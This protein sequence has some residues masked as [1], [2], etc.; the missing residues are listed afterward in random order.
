MLAVA[1]KTA[2]ERALAG[3]AVA[4]LQEWAYLQPVKAPPQ[5]PQ[6]WSRISLAHM[7][8]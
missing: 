1:G 3:E 6:W 8:G 7:D 5:S 2:H 4:V